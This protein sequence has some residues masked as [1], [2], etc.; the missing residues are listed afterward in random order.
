MNTYFLASTLILS[1]GQV[2]L[3][4]L[5]V[6][7]AIGLG[8]FAGKTYLAQQSEK[9]LQEAANDSPLIR[10]YE[11]VD[12]RPHGR[13]IKLAGLA[14]ALAIVL[15]VFAWTQFTS[16]QVL[17]DFFPEPDMIEMDVPPTAAPPKQ[18]PPA[19][20]PPPQQSKVDIII[21]ET[22]EPIEDPEIQPKEDPSPTP[23]T[24]TGPTDP[25]ATDLP[26]VIEPAEPEEPA[27]PKIE[28]IIF[29]AEQ[30]PR[31]PG[32]EDMA[33]TTKAKKQCADQALLGYIYERINYPAMA[34]ENGIQGIAVVSFIVWND[35]S[36]RDV[37]IVRDP[38]AGLGK[39][40]K[41]VVETMKRL[42]ENWTPGKQR[43]R[44]VNVRYNLP[45]RFV[46]DDRG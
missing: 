45:V 11:A 14:S 2:A 46:L 40:A 16:E 42:P 28:E 7:A 8:I 9:A 41:R 37:K 36:I 3:G 26:P 19:L 5:A 25:N 24:Y 22:P 15:I 38:G 13:N 35:G 18:L 6:G 44:A 27:E 12:L 31:F 39:E 21:D 43:G 34:R 33:G 23:S 1:G 32:C 17:A 20:P 4:L 10:K 29:I 30:M